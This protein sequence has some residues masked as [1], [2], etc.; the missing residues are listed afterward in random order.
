MDDI[1]DFLAQ[2]ATRY[3]KLPMFIYGHSLGGNL[4]LNFML[5]RKPDVV[6]RHRD[7][8]LAETGF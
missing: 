8:S 1:A 3:P 4:V 7:G 5:R 6:G 2:V